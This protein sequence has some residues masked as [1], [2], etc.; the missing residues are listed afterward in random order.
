MKKDGIKEKIEV[1]F[2]KRKCLIGIIMAML[3]VISCLYFK[4]SIKAASV[5]AIG[6]I[7]TGAI[8]VQFNREIKSIQGIIVFLMIF[9]TV[10]LSQFIYGYG[11]QSLEKK[12]IFLNM[13]CVSICICIVY[14]FFIDSRLSLVT[15]SFAVLVL[16]TTN[17]FVYEFRGNELT[18]CDFQSIKTATNV[19]KGYHF[20]PS[21]TVVYSWITFFLLVIMLY[22]INVDKKDETQTKLYKRMGVISIGVV[23]VLVLFI[24]GRNVNIKHWERQGTAMNGYM[25][26]FTLQLKE[27]FVS[28][29]QEYNMEIINECEEKYVDED[30]FVKEKKKYPNVIVIMNES[31][32]DF[33]ILGNNFN[34][35]IEVTPFLNNLK[36]NTIRGYALSSVYGGNTANSE[37]EFLTGNT[38]AFLPQGSIPYQQYVKKENYSLARIF[39]RL[40]YQCKTTHP[41]L[42]EGWNRPTV[43]PLLGFEESTFID[44]YPQKNIL[45]KYVSDEEMYGEII[46]NFE[47][48]QSDIPMFLFSVTMQNHGD[49]FYEGENYKQEIEL[50]GYSKE[51]PDVEQYLTLTHESDKAFEKLIHYFEKVNEPVAILFYGDHF[52][53]L[54]SDFYE[55]VHGGKFATLDEQMLKYKIPFWVWT[56]YDI[57]EK[58]IDCTSINYLSNYLFEAAEL[59]LSGYN[60]LLKDVQEQIPAINAMGYYSKSEK[61]FLPISEAKGAEADTLNLY[62]QLQYNAMFDKNNRSE[63]LFPISNVKEP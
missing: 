47:Q 6:F 4:G 59:P 45:R 12:M 57:D 28:K 26:N 18:P 19:M 36:D 63:S 16:S 5:F 11:L 1:N 29:P 20:E 14:F 62:E 32:A 25:L 53:K 51:Y 39:E 22:S 56:N 3:S 54:S 61:C 15:G 40:G 41:Y 17:Y 13:V 8:R 49:Y 30:F 2:D 35:N 50:E 31:F 60:Y 58:D 27:T 48:K 37:F 23:L 46:N 7:I 43:Y 21:V 34:T 33:Q 24:A 55:E 44:D 9:I 52:P 42:A 10:F 38:M